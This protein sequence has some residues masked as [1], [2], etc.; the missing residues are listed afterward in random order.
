[1]PL[2]LRP[3][4]KKDYQQAVQYAIVGMHF[5]RYFANKIVGC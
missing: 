3:L 5:E 1:M 2:E 4:Q